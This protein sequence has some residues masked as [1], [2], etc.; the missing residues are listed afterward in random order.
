MK[1]RPERYIP[2]IAEPL[3]MSVEQRNL[4]ERRT[5]PFL[6]DGRALSIILAECY[7]QGMKDC[8]QALGE[9]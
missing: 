7:I 3:P 1:T 9:K 2:R 4:I 6:C 8:L 5:L